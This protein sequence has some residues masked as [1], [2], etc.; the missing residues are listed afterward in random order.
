M[1]ETL[2]FQFRVT[3]PERDGVL[4]AKP[5][6]TTIGRQPGNDWHLEHLMVSRHH[7]EIEC[8]GAVCR[9]TDVGSSNGTRVND[10]TLETN[11]P[12][13][14]VAGDQITIGPF[15]VVYEPV[16]ESEREP[17]PEEAAPAPGPDAVVEPALAPD[18]EMPEPAADQPVAVEP[19]A[20]PPAAEEVPPPPAKPPVGANGELP[21]G[22]YLDYSRYLQYL[23]EIYHTDFMAR[24]LAAFESI[25]GP[26]EW[27]VDNFDLF[28]GAETAPEG[29]L[30]WLANWFDLTFD[31]SWNMVQRR[32]LLAEASEIF[33]RRGTPWA[34]SRVLEIYLGRPVTIE[35]QA[36]DLDPFTFVVALPVRRSEVKRDLIEMLI[37]A[38]KPAHTMYKLT[39]A[40]AE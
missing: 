25:L 33:E 18:V 37:D 32:C 22:L 23:P 2:R 40:G 35:D 7:A 17:E 38:H 20:H 39:F 24:F 14:L 15:R 6:T 9:L 31:P 26:I 28:L 11:V 29:F 3:G 4:V 12:H 10:E 36:E 13:T 16:V 5:G 27:T 1:S 34:L 30:P 19:V 8:E 21:P